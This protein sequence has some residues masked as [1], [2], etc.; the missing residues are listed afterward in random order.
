MPNFYKPVEEVLCDWL[1]EKFPG[2]ASSRW[3]VTSCACVCLF[4]FGAH[5]V[6]RFLVRARIRWEESTFVWQVDIMYKNS[7][8][9]DPNEFLERTI[10]SGLLKNIQ[11]SIVRR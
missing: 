6:A 5:A 9:E 1:A 4:A 7:T 11:S 3:I 2:A 8:G 10:L